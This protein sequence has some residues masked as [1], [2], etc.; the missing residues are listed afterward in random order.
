M[1][2]V[3]VFYHSH[4]SRYQNLV[5]SSGYWHDKL[6]DPVVLTLKLQI[7]TALGA[8]IARIAL[9]QGQHSFKRCSL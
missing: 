1:A 3:L 6:S 8:L 5:S 4:G 9:R 7:R 2:A